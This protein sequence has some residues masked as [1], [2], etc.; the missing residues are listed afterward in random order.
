LLLIRRRSFDHFLISGFRRTSPVI[1]SL[2]VSNHAS[3]PGFVFTAADSSRLL[4]PRNAPAATNGAIPLFFI[5][6]LRIDLSRA[7]N[8]RRTFAFPTNSGSLNGKRGHKLLL[9]RFVFPTL[10]RSATDRNSAK[11][12]GPPTGSWSLSDCC[13]RTRVKILRALRRISGSRRYGAL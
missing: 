7:C 2:I 9:G 13:V 8:R 11:Y 6:T 5:H 3:V 12:R 1:L 10:D 4:S